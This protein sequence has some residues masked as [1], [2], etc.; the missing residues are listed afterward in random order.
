MAEPQKYKLTARQKRMLS[1]YHQRQHATAQTV[2]P[3][4]GAIDSVE[5]IYKAL[6][7]RDEIKAKA[8]LMLMLRSWLT[9]VS[10][11]DPVSGHALHTALSISWM[12]WRNR[13]RMRH[14]RVR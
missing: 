8:L 11:F 6:N 2:E 9:E 3:S 12:M 4:I 14:L 10:S 1:D 5:S 13:C 7:G